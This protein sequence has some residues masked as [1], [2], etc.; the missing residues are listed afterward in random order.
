MWPLA[1]LLTLGF[2]WAQTPLPDAA[3][4]ALRQAQAR[5]S[6]AL[7]SYPIPYPDKPL[8]KEAFD[9]GNRA[10]EL[11]PDRPEPLRFLAQ[12]YTQT[13]WTIRAW[14]SWLAY[15]DAGGAMDASA[16]SAAS[17]SG[18]DLAQAAIRG[19]RP[20]E[21]ITILRDVVDL[22]PDA[23][24][25]NALLGQALLDRG[26]AAAA[27]PYLR[28]AA[29]GD[30]RYQQLLERATLADAIGLSAADA[31]IAGKNMRVQGQHA[32][33]LAMFQQVLDQAPEY[34]L[35]L[36]LAA[37]SAEA[38]DRPDLASGYWQRVLALAP[39][40]GEA[41]S[42]LDRTHFAARWGA[43]AAAAYERGREALRT[44]NRTAG[45]EAFRA[46]LAQNPSMAPAEAALGTLALQDDA[47]EEAVRRLRNAVRLD[48]TDAATRDTLATAEA[49]LEQENAAAAAAAAS[50][51]PPRA[52]ATTTTAPAAAAPPPT[53]TPAANT[54]AASTPAAST[55]APPAA[56]ATPTPR[57]AA[58]AAAA[59][60]S[61]P[62]LLTLLD[63]R[64]THR[65]PQ[66]GGSGA[67]TFLNA[68][69]STAIDLSS[70]VDYAGG[71]VYVRLEI[72]DKPSAAPLRYQLCLIPDDAITVRPACSDPG[73][74]RVTDQASVEM[75]QPL[76]AF[77]GAAT[78]NWHRGLQQILLVLRNDND[79]PLDDR[80]TANLPSQRPD[81]TQYYPLSVHV[82]AVLV[83][84][85]GTFPGWGSP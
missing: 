54:P 16:R 14:S 49:R 4:T 68:D 70:P 30:A 75:A 56:T 27:V 36:R 38:A 62:K 11:A 59:P 3:A 81:L 72:E 19:G 61:R 18:T 84:A 67:F 12:A 78:V 35:A 83:P 50:A 71:R 41:R 23:V 74:L 22:T 9:L 5:A 80:Y 65:L 7:A 39:T 58:P 52:P 63:A 79:A 31:F 66:D 77:D 73:R 37:R 10:H 21:A 51:P 1:V 64:L 45:A 53:S 33:A 55:P 46:A 15:R 42:G 47:L 44:G 2:A 13:G 48:P 57:P 60:A 40:D 82:T 43:A 20:D 76:S 28:T 24:A 34:V 17:S 69:D 25:A 32:Q 85:G 8:W 6:E 29:D 26:D